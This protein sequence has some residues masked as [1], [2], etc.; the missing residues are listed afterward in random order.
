MSP[1]ELAGHIHGMD[2]S[3]LMQRVG[4][5]DLPGV[6]VEDMDRQ[7]QLTVD[8][9]ALIRYLRSPAAEPA[10]GRYQGHADALLERVAE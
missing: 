8:P 5:H 4:R 6:W 1:G 9:A 2:A 10:L 3:R 7:D